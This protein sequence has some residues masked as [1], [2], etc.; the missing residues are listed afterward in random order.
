MRLIKLL[1]LTGCLMH[2]MMSFLI[3]QLDRVTRVFMTKES[4]YLDTIEKYF[5]SLY[6]F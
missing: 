4:S 6:L 1:P 2:Q 5:P 3:Y